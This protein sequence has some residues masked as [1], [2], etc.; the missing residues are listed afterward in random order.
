MRHRLYDSAAA[1][2]VIAL[3]VV[4]PQ[5]GAIPAVFAQGPAAAAPAPKTPKDGALADLTGYWVSIVSEDW[6]FRMITAPRGDYPNV[7][8]NAEG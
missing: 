7:P 1:A 8:L 3:T 4:W 5:T 2:G 6:R